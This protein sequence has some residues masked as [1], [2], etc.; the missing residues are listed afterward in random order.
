MTNSGMSMPR[1]RRGSA[2][3]A[4]DPVI[5]EVQKEATKNFTVKL[6]VS[7]KRRIDLAVAQDDR[8]MTQWCIAAFEAQLE[9]GEE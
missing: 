2:A 9:R 4:A 3:A 7:L 1:R 6:P 5:N 8:N